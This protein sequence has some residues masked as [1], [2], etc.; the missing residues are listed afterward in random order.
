MPEIFNS[1]YKLVYKWD[2]ESLL[3]YYKGLFT[4]AALERL[5][6]INQTQLGH[7]AAG[8]SKPRK[9]QVK[10]IENALHELGEELC[11]IAL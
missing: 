2:V 4:K 10:K 6:G 9:L 11:D 1:K 7:Y 5:T 3:D 8:R